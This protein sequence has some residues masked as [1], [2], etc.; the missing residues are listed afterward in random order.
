MLDLKEMHA[1]HPLLALLPDLP[2]STV[3]RVTTIE[4]LHLLQT[5]IYSYPSMSERR[6]LRLEKF[7]STH[8]KRL[9]FIVKQTVIALLILL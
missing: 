5:H 1:L 4:V 6:C 9:S 7:L 2:S 8:M 3:T